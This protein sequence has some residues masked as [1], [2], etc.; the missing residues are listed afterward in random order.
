[1]PATEELS[2]RGPKGVAAMILLVLAGGGVGSYATARPDPEPKIVAM[3]NLTEE[4]VKAY[5]TQQSMQYSQLAR[6]EC[7]KSISDLN[8]R[9]ERIDTIAEDVAYLRAYVINQPMISRKT[10]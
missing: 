1:M 4:R 10:K 3:N 6:D 5:A 9:L 8:R 7:N 2:I